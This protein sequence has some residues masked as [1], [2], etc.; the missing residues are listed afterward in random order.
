M[1][2]PGVGIDVERHIRRANQDRVL[3]SRHGRV[4]AHA[5][6][7]EAVTP[8]CVPTPLV[9]RLTQEGEGRYQHQHGLRA[10]LLGCFVVYGVISDSG[11]DFVTLFA[12][13]LSLLVTTVLAARL[14]ALR[15]S[16]LDPLRTLRSE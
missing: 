13:A 14:P 16:R 10:L 4:G 9:E 2:S 3:L 7:L 11:R 6:V 5:E 8:R 12:V 1:H 15:A